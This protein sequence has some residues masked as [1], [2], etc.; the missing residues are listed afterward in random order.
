MVPNKRFD[1]NKKDIAKFSR[2]APQFN[3]PGHFNG[4]KRKKINTYDK[5][6]KG[7]KQFS[8]IIYFRLILVSNK[9]NNYNHKFTSDKNK[10]SKVIEL[11]CNHIFLSLIHI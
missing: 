5:E 1:Q 6:E 11:D 10:T 7:N 3:K 9:R 2:Y 4:S 8:N